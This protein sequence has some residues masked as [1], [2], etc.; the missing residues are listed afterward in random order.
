MPRVAPQP[1][2]VQAHRWDA[3]R[4]SFVPVGDLVETRT[5]FAR[6]RGARFLK[7]PIPWDWMIRASQLPGKALILG[8]CIWRLSGA[9]GRNTVP[10]SN[11]E[12]QPFEIDRAAKSRGLRAL[13]KAGLISISRK[14]G[15][16]PLVTL[17]K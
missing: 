13:E 8:L 11:S 14:P 1:A 17:M 4:G 5:R 16:W 7:G 6:S 2:A 15:R 3:E 10:L 9:T 12:V